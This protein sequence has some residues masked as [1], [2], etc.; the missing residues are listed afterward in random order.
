MTN[1]ELAA[2]E[3]AAYDPKN[4][5]LQ[6]PLPGQTTQI[7]TELDW[8]LSGYGQVPTVV[9]DLMHIAAGAYLAD[10]KTARGLAFSRDIELTVQLHNPK[11]WLGEAGELIVDLLAWI[12]GDAWTLRPV[13]LGK[14]AVVEAADNHLED[15]HL[16]SETMLLSGG[17]DSF[18]GAVD[19]LSTANIRL[20]VGHRDSASSVQH[21]QRQVA[22]WLKTVKTDFAWQRHALGVAGKKAERTTRTRSLLFMTMAIA[23]AAGAGAPTV[24][25]PENGFTS[26][27]MPLIPSRGG[28]RSTKSTHPW[29]FAL[30]SRLLAAAEIPVL[31]QNPYLGLTK[32]ELLAR[33]AEHGFPGFLE[34]TA[35]TLSCAK[36]DTGRVRGGN[37]NINCGLCFACL[38]R[39]GAYQAAG[40]D[41]P[42]DYLVHRLKGAERNAFYLKRRDDLWALDLAEKRDVE[43]DDLIASAAW[44]PGTDFS[45]TLDLVKRGRK[46][47]FSVDR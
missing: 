4:E 44:P 9:A 20:H 6:W 27:N 13:G 26:M 25:V 43:E 45:A 42:T 8:P 18:C 1:Y 28:A 36:L 34:A 7:R 35:V 29:T 47:L 14:G 10:L 40:L 24:F 22:Q 23:A 3:A 39:R 38:V 32:G 11:I 16:R 19:H 41:D 37:P 17:L 46:E 33:A 15:T 12:S 31:V 2:P 5:L 30:V 21:A